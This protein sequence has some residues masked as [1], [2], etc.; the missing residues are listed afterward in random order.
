M[1]WAAPIDKFVARVEEIVAQR[2]P[3]EVACA[4][5]ASK[6]LSVLGYVGQIMP[7]PHRFRILE[8]RLANKILRLATNSLDANSAFNLKVVGCP[9]LSRP[10]ATLHAA[11]VRA[12]LKT[13][14]GAS[15]QHKILHEAAIDSLPLE[16]IRRRVFRP[17][18]WDGDAYCTNLHFA[19][20]AEIRDPDFPGM[21]SALAQLGGQQRRGLLKGGLQQNI[22]KTILS[23]ALN[24]WPALLRKRLSVFGV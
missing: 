18:G 16:L 8:L 5:F 11:R 17:D 4:R 6:A 20:S 21:G 10:S 14:K 15:D 24:P 12:S 22:H 13:I 3:L 9:K 1:N 2:P 23:C 7:P 19:K